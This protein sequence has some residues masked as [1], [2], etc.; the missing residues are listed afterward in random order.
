MDLK[1]FTEARIGIA[2]NSRLSEISLMAREQ[3]NDPAK[4]WKEY[5]PVIFQLI[6]MT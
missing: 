4:Q 5:P 1:Q 2:A 3:N 6:G